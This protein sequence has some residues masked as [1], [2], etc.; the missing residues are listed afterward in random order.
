VFTLVSAETGKP[1]AQLWQL[2]IGWSSI[3]TIGLAA[4]AW[5]TQKAIGIP[6]GQGAFT[7]ASPKTGR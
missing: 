6:C 2:V 1:S 5:G 7:E 4:R 3:R